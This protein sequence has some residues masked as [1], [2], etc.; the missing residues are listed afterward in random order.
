MLT[1]VRCYH[2][3][4]AIK[5]GSYAHCPIKMWLHTTP[6]IPH[7]LQVLTIMQTHFGKESMYNNS[8]SR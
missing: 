3:H 2:Y 1:V 4:K 7:M 6:T 8:K 5:L